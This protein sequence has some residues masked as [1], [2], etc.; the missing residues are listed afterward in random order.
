[1]DKQQKIEDIRKVVI[2]ANPSIL[3]LVFG[4][5]IVSLETRMI[6]MG[7]GVYWNSY[8]GT[9]FVDMGSLVIDEIIGREIRL[10]DVLLAIKNSNIRVMCDVGIFVLPNGNWQTDIQWNLHYDSLS[11]QSDETISFLWDLLIGRK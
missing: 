7:K 8:L 10:S 5:E 3:D 11:S 2:E 9:T 4:C 1:M 6:F